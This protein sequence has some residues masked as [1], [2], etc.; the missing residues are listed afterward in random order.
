MEIAGLGDVFSVCQTRGSSRGAEL[1]LYGEWGGGQKWLREQ[2]VS[3]YRQGLENL[4]VC[5]AKCPNKFGNYVEK[6]SAK[7]QRHPYTFLISTYL[8][9]LKKKTGTL[10][11]DFPSYI[12]KISWSMLL[13]K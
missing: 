6:Q 3:L 13:R 10:L 8:H 4:V 7:G 2:D 9:S 1:G 5:C 12:T 11:S